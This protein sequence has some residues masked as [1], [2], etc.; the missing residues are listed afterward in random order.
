MLFLLAQSGGEETATGF[1]AIADAN[2]LG[3]AITGMTI[4]FVALVGISLFIAA[5]P[6][7]LDLLDRWLPDL[8]SG[9][10]PATPAEQVSSDEEKIIAAIGFVLHSEMQRT[11]SDAR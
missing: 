2:G 7:V 8:E 10:G 1:K 6:R 11:S 3:I 9:H 4:V 5:M